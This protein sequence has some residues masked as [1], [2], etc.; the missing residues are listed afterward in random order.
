MEHSSQR[1][2]L[3]RSVTLIVVVLV[4]LLTI[5][6]LLSASRHSGQ[7][8]MRLETRINQVEQRMYT[9]ENSL[10]NL[11]Q[12]T[13]FGSAGSRGA[14][15]ED[16]IRLRSE[17]DTLQRRI[18]DDECALAKL[19]ERTLARETKEARRRSGTNRSDPCRSQVDAPL[20]LPNVR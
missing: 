1:T 20:S 14:G 10:R 5:V 11:E 13:R 18:A 8:A 16:L 17:I 2:L 19:D 4:G 12:Q 15:Q 9:I 3:A 7:D 6:T